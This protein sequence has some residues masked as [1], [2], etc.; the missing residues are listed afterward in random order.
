MN[1]R[2]LIQAPEPDR[3]GLWVDSYLPANQP[4][5]YYGPQQNLIDVSWLRSVL[6]RHRW[7]VLACITLALIAGLVIT[8]LTTPMYQARAT[9]QIDPYGNWIVEG[10]DLQPGMH[11]SEIDPYMETQAEV[12]RSRKLARVVAEDLNL[13]TRP[14]FLGANIDS[15]RPPGRTDEQ[16]LEDKTNRAANM[17]RG[18]VEAQMTQ[19]DT[20]II[21]IVYSSED[22]VFAAQMANGYADAFVRSEARQNVENNSYAREYLE[23]QIQVIRGQLQDAEKA[24]NTYARNSGIVT[25]GQTT[26]EDGTV[27]GTITTANLA[28]INSTVTQARAARIAAEQRWRAVSG[29]PA[30]QLPEVQ[31]NQVVQ[32]LKSE[33]AQMMTE[34]TNLRQRY[35]DQ[36]PEI[37]DLKAR[38]ETIDA[39]I[40]STSADIKASI[41]NNFIVARNQENALAGELASAKQ[42][43]LAEQDQQ[44]EYEGLERQANALRTQLDA[45]LERYTSISTAANVQTGTLTKLDSAVVPGAPVSPSLS[46]NLLVALIAGLG[47]AAGLVLLRELFDDRLRSLDEVEDKLGVPLLGHTPFVDDEEIDNHEANQFSAL[48]EAYASIRST[49]DFAIPRDKN[50]LQLTSSQAGEG[51][52]TTSLILAELFARLGRKTLLID[53]D[54]RKPSL[55]NL[56]GIERPEA[57]LAEVLLGH[58]KLDDALVKGAHENLQILPVGT[59][60]P[61]PVEILSSREL[62][63]F[64]EEQRENYSL[65]IFDTAPVMGIADAPLL[66]RYVDATIFVVEAN[67]VHFGQAKAAIRRLRGVGGNVLGTVLTKYRAL[68]AGQSYSYQYRYYEY[69]KS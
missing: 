51:K 68:E 45:L 52:S 10:Q 56:V 39:Q 34:L 19:R 66:S 28:S 8:L 65:I 11:S 29:L 15:S 41:R 36:F 42:D 1:E 40:A 48:M 59:I 61:N 46:R 21:S 6:F 14:D 24:A 18:G 62:R 49:V 47:L 26:T 58:T 20:R 43:T 9:V 3:G 57:G 35:N 25:Q 7:L 32:N 2:S 13:G 23:E 67:R 44:V 60:P 5:E 16:W 53:A 31:T 30:S 38:M 27:T 33:K 69:G 64:I 37:V 50:V 17:L 63:E 22:P 4:Q 55:A 54:L 12:I